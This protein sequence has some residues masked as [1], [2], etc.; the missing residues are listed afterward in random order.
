MVSFPPW[1]SS[2]KVDFGISQAHFQDLPRREVFDMVFGVSGQLLKKDRP[3]SF[4]KMFRLRGPIRQSEEG[5]DRDD[6]SQ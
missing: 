4:G 6:N 3:L 2:P 1:S 5:D